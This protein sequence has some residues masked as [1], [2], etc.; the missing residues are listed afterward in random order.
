MRRKGTWAAVLVALPIALVAIGSVAYFFSQIA[1]PCVVWRGS[2]SLP[3]S[4]SHSCRQITGQDE[5][6]LRAAAEAV[7]VQGVI[8][9]A[10]ALGIWGAIRSRQTAVIIAGL[11][12]LLEMIPTMFSVAPLA[13]LAGVGFLVIAY[14]MPDHTASR[15]Q[16]V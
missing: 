12:M 5:T 4:A 1:S 2:G 7:A 15:P 13:L 14:R 6:T 11:L 10:A 9:L 3:A 8:L 16:P